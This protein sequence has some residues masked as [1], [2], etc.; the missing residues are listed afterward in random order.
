MATIGIQA[1]SRQQWLGKLN[2]EWHEA[3]LWIY[4]A[5]VVLHWIEHIVQAGQ[6][7]IFEMARPEAL[8]GIGYLFPWLV[9]SELMHFG[10]AVSMFAGLVVLR[11]GFRGTARTWWMASL[12]IQAWH[13]FE[14]TLLQLQAA[15]QFNL[16]GAPVPTS[17]FQLWLPRP[18]LHLIYN[19]AVFIP[20][21]AAM[22]YHTRPDQAAHLSCSCAD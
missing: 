3:A 13:L 22:W 19:A 16:F 6:I 7:W 14:H 8:G 2:R 4:M 11:H 21:V 12:W 20:M 9:T 5:I 10:F 18:E 17:V 15:F 1:P